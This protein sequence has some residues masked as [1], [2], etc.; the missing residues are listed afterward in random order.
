MLQR[1]RSSTIALA[2][3]ACAAA[4]AITA[5]PAD[6]VVSAW[7]AGGYVPTGPGCTITNLTGSGPL[8]QTTWVDATVPKV[9]DVN[10]NGGTSVTI[11]PAGKA[12]TFQARVHQPCGGVS[13]LIERLLRNESHQDSYTML[14]QSADV[15]GGMFGETRAQLP[16]SAGVYRMPTMLVLPRYGAFVLDSL[17]H[18]VISSPP[19]DY[20]VAVGPWSLKRMYL[21]RQTTLATSQSATRVRKGKTVKVFG[22]LKY[23]TDTGYV[24]DNGEKVLA[25]VK[26]GTKWVTKATL[27]ASSTGAVTYSFAPTRT[28]RVRLVHAAVYSGRFTAAITSTTRT[29][30]V[31]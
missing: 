31:R 7:P 22:T 20:T 6:A 15:F 14:A 9:V 3:A 5:A 25:Q 17:F 21:L 29:I 13:L 27:T 24:A 8:L 11:P 18:L 28:T 26:V 23:A 1:R 30:T 16:S 12:V 4:L 19:S 2:A 10:V